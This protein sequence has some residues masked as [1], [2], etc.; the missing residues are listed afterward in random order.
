MTLDE[1]RL[2][3]IF[4]A[5]SNRTRRQL[6]ADLRKRPGRVN[7]LAR[8]YAVSLNAISKHLFVLE[9]AGLIE[10]RQE[11]AFQTCALNANVLASADEW[12][13][14]YRVYW[15]N[16]LDELARFVESGTQ[17]N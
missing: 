16:Q 1:D 13:G 17:E 4:H 6:L 7:E 15:D 12:I 3:N 10:R 8:P 14:A 9:K 2:D 11:G 5:L